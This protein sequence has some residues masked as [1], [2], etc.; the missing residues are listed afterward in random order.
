[1]YST[2]NL[3]QI[4]ARRGLKLID[5]NKTIGVTHLNRFALRVRDWKS[6]AALLGIEQQDVD[7]IDD[8][9]KKVKHKRLALFYRWWLLN[10][11]NATFIKLANVLVELQDRNLIE[12]LIDDVYFKQISRTTDWAALYKRT[13]SRITLFCKGMFDNT[14]ALPCMA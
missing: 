3:D 13:F 4:L 12:F 14:T 1:M 9:Q 8:E 6:C 11:E 5:L 7:D 2:V 10:G